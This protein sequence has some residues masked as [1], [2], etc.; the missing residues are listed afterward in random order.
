MYFI[1]KVEN[2]ANI[3]YAKAWD[4]LEMLRDKFLVIRLK[5]DN[6]DDVNLILNY[7][8]ETEQTSNR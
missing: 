1:D 5:F 7:S 6:F 2:Q 4:E 3:N 8:I